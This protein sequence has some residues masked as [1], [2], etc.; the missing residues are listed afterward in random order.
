[1]RCRN[2]A[3]APVRDGLIPRHCSSWPQGSSATTLVRLAAALLLT[4]PALWSGSGR[5]VVDGSF[6]R[7]I[8]LFRGQQH[9]RPHGGSAGRVDGESNSCGALVV[10]K[11]DDHVDVMVAKGEVEA[12]DPATHALGKRSDCI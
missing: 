3:G 5:A 6:R 12:L 7:R 8:D 2:A 1:M 4:V 10:R 11:L 9:H